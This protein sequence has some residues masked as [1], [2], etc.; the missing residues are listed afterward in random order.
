MNSSI[1]VD[2]RD[3]ILAKGAEVMTRRGYHGAGVQEIVQ[4]AG[5]PKGSS[6]TTSPAKKTLPCRPCSRFTSRAWRV[7]PKP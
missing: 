4:A 2:K 1:R 5:V 6:T 7:M 3:L